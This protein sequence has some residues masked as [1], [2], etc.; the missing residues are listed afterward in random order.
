MINIEIDKEKWKLVDFEANTGENKTKMNL[1]QD[2]DL[3]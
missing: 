1:I 3:S 2:R